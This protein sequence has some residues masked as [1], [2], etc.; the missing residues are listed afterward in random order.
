M[1]SDLAWHLGGGRR[2]ALEVAR[3]AAHRCGM[4][5]DEWLDRVILDSAQQQGVEPTLVAA[6]KLHDP[7]PGARKL[8]TCVLLSSSTL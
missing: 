6:V 3:E 7:P 4:S 5:I 1:K 8:A 2:Q